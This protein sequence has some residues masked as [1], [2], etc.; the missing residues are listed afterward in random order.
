VRELDNVIQRLVVMTDQKVIEAPDL[1]SPMRFSAL[2]AAGFDR[3]LAEVE[4]EYVRNVL[5]SVGNN[6]TKAAQILGLIGR[7]SGRS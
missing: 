7:R 4:T 6:K 5:A 3:S 2:K 1:P